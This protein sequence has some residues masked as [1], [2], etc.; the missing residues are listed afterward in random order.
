MPVIENKSGAHGGRAG[1]LGIAMMPLDISLAAVAKTP[2]HDAQVRELP[3]FLMA[4][5][6]VGLSREQQHR[7]D[8]GLGQPTLIALSHHQLDEP[9]DL[10]FGHSDDSLASRAPD[11]VAQAP[12]VTFA[13]WA[14]PHALV[15]TCEWF[16]GASAVFNDGGLGEATVEDAM[17]ALLALSGLDETTTLEDIFGTAAAHRVPVLEAGIEAVELV[18]G[19]PTANG[20]VTVVGTG[21]QVAGLQQ[22]GGDAWEVLELSANPARSGQKSTV[23]DDRR[24]LCLN[25]DS[26]A[27]GEHYGSDAL[28]A[29]AL[30]M[31]PVVA[32]AAWVDAQ[33]LLLRTATTALHD[34]KVKLGP[35]LEQV[36]RMKEDMLA[37]DLDSERID[38]DAFRRWASVNV[39]SATLYGLTLDTVAGRE[40]HVDQASTLVAH[41]L[42]RARMERAATV[43]SWTQVLAPVAGISVVAGL[44][45]AFV[46]VSEYLPTTSSPA[47]VAAGL[48]AGSLFVGALVGIAIQ[49]KMAD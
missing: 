30:H 25:Q 29:A 6:F 27:H 3:T 42:E 32:H 46:T 1:A 26:F 49:R 36:W 21:S 43:T 10:F 41:A 44:L 13:L 7:T 18:E 11:F 34:P 2:G 9:A 19:R 4:R 33:Y 5:E 28:G 47:W 22:A 31:L 23:R 38:L 24:A 8:L 40:E 35:L 39:L 12:S 14:T 20:L 16:A 37:R 15:L 45:G 17:R 48:T